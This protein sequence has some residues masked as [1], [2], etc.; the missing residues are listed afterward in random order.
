M[1]NKSCASISDNTLQE[2]SNKPFLGEPGKGEGHWRAKCPAVFSYLSLSYTN[3][4]CQK[5][6]VSNVLDSTIFQFNAMLCQYEK[7]L[8]I[9]SQ[10]Y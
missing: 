6:V 9:E 1:R 2:D 4:K 5:S 7:D 10:K 8:Q 3:Q